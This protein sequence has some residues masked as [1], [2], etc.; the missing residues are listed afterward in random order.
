[1]VPDGGLP[2]VLQHHEPG[3]LGD[4]EPERVLARASA[5]AEHCRGV[6][7][8]PEDAPSPRPRVP[9]IPPH[10]PHHATD[11]RH[12]V[13]MHVQDLVMHPYVVA[14]RTV[15]DQIRVV[16]Y[17]MKEET[18]IRGGVRGKDIFVLDKD[19]YVDA[20]LN[21]KPSV[22]RPSSREVF[23]EHEAEIRQGDY[24]R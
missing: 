23:E 2:G 15:D 22:K 18:K 16:K 4:E 8:L 21:K 10:G 7:A 3:G 12:A 6:R 14:L 5:S 19:G 17:V 13:A 11:P 24:A 1:M 9:A 20:L